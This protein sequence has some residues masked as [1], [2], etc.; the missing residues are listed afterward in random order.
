MR[1]YVKS[2]KWTKGSPRHRICLFLHG[3]QA[4][5]PCRFLPSVPGGIA[6]FSESYCLVLGQRGQM[7]LPVTLK[8]WY[9][10]QFI[11]GKAQREPGHVAGTAKAR[12]WLDS[13]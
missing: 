11:A 6:D 8:C 2:E 4:L 7:V 3:F 5:C 12:R 10:A 1:H 9:P 13:D